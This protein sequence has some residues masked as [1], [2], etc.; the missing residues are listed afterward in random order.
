MI[1]FHCLQDIGL[2]N[3]CFLWLSREHGNLVSEGLTLCLVC[4]TY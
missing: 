1:L 2:I 3:S 4:V